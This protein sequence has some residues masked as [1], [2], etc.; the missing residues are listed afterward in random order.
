VG[1]P[2]GVQGGMVVTHGTATD[3][4]NNEDVRRAYLGDQ[5]RI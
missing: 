5:F 2:V 1:Q 4:I 3:M